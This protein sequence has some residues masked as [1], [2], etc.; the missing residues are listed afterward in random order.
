MIRNIWF[1]WS[2]PKPSMN[3]PR[4]KTHHGKDVWRGPDRTRIPPKAMSRLRRTMCGWHII[5]T[6]TTTEFLI[7]AHRL[8]IL[9][10]GICTKFKTKISRV[11]ELLSKHRCIL[12]FTKGLTY[13]KTIGGVRLPFLCTLSD[14]ALYLYQVS[15]TYMKWLKSYWADMYWNLQRS[16]IP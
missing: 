10:T 2:F 14:D 13:L 8:M 16:I 3:Q 1:A 7:T 9:Y 5:A 4:K 6:V 15:K 12:K 11:S